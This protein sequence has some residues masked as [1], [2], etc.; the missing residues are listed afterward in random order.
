MYEML[1][2]F[3]GFG[4]KT[5]FGNRSTAIFLVLQTQYIM[6]HLYALT[7]YIIYIIFICIEVSEHAPLQSIESYLLRYHTGV[8]YSNIIRLSLREISPK[9]M[10]SLNLHKL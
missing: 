2:N 7:Q 1:C 6:V 10:D 3:Y 5:L 9:A 8:R 4:T